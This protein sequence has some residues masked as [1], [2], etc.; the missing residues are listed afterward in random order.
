MRV[1]PNVVST[2]AGRLASLPTSRTVHNRRVPAGFSL[3][4]ILVVIGIILVVLGI[5]FAIMANAALAVRLHGS[6]GDYANLLQNARI[7]AVKDDKYYT[8]RADANAN[9]PVA[10][11]DVN[12]SGTYDVGE[13]MTAFRSGTAPAPFG[14]GPA[15]TNLKAQFLPASPTGQASVAVAAVGPTFGPR[16]LPCT[17]WP[18]AGGSTICPYIT[19][20]SF[21]TFIQGTNGGW[22]AVTVT[23][24]GRIR[25]WVY[26]ADSSTWSPLD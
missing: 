7:R 26:A 14:S 19:P 11:V 20:T 17:P 15:L 1:P 4:E 3:L 13:P 10:F 12:G 21:I 25:E 23:P 2:V 9:P 24:A 18:G 6:A 22:A 16:G 5:S 8:V